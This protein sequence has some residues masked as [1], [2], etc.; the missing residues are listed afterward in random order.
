MVEEASGH[1]RPRPVL[2]RAG[3]GMASF[4]L[5]AASREVVNDDLALIDALEVPIDRPG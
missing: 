2:E 5:P 4:E 3:P 1:G